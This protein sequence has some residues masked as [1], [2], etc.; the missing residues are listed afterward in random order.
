MRVGR[1]IPSILVLLTAGCVHWHVERNAPGKVDL[2]QPPRKIECRAAE[3]PEDPGENYLVFAPGAFVGGGGTSVSGGR[4]AVTTGLETSLHFGSASRS[5]FDDEF[6]AGVLPDRALGL[7]LGWAFLAPQS[8]NVAYAELQ[9]R[10]SRAYALAPGWEW[11]PTSGRNGPQATISLGPFF[12]RAGYL[13]HSRFD[14]S[15]GIF[16]K[17]FLS[18]IWSR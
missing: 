10:P 3:A 14:V 11:E 7:N 5:H 8:T 15:A 13:I 2:S 6:F 12:L 1:P 9:V 16:L 4:A 18:W 17:G